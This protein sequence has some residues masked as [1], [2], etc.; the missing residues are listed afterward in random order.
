MTDLT[1]KQPITPTRSF[2]VGD[3]VDVLDREHKV[4]SQRKVVMASGRIVK[5]DCG[6]I[7]KQ[8]GWWIGDDDRSWPFPSIR[9]SASDAP[10]TPDQH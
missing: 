6:R 4:L 2:K 5:T 8:S 1:Y 9:L 10:V 7:W 3:V